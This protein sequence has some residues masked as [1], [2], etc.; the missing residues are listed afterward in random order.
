[1]KRFISIGLFG[2]LFFLSGA[3]CAQIKRVDTTELSGRDGYRIICNNKDTLNNELNIRPVGFDHDAHD[4]ATFMRGRIYK[5]EIDDLNNVGFP[6][7]V[8]YVAMGG[9]AQYRTVYTIVSINNKSFTIAGV[10][11]VQLDAKYKDGYRG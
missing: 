3:V 2:I 1:M 10:P 7:L 8:L 5:S 4:R 11:D 6:D 9:T